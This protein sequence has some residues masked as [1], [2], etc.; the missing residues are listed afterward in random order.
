MFYAIK[1]AMSVR[2]R[3]DF[4]NLEGV[5]VPSREGLRLA[6]PGFVHAGT[7]R[8]FAAGVV[9]VLAVGCG[10]PPPVRPWQREHLSRR[11]MQFDDG[12]E[13]RFRQH[14]FGSREGADGGYGH[15]GG[16]CGCN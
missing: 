6:R 11:A 7:L 12:L 8:L 9:A 15:A 10:H 5:P 1:T 4:G 13:G 3:M 16:G 14:L 2:L